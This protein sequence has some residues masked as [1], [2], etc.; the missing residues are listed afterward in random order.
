M[1]IDT[2]DSWQF[3]LSLLAIAVITGSVMPLNQRWV[4]V[5]ALLG[6]LLMFNRKWARQWMIKS[7]EEYEATR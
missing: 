2:K 4:I 1:N 7:I 6:L 5:S 3:G